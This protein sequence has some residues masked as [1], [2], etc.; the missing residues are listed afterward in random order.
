LITL[1]RNIAR[2]I[3]TIFRRALGLSVNQCSNQLV[4]LNADSDGSVIRSA[5]SRSAI[6]YRDSTSLPKCSLQA[7]LEMFKAFGSSKHDLVTLTAIADEKIQANWQDGAVPRTGTWSSRTERS[8]HDFPSAPT[9]YVENPPNFLHAIREAISTTD[10]NPTRFALNCLRLRGSDGSVA[11]TDGRQVFKQS[12][13]EFSFEDE[14]LFYPAQVYDAK[15]LPTN[16]PVSIGR[17]ETHI[18]F[19][20]GPWTFFQP[21]EKDR[22]FPRIEDVIPPINDSDSTLDWQS[23]DA[24]F[25]VD[26]LRRLPGTE[27]T[28]QPVTIDLNGKVAIRARATADTQPT[29]LVL[30]NSQRSGEEIRLAT[31]RRYLSRAAQL[32]FERVYFPDNTTPAVCNDDHRTYVWALLSKEG[33]VAPSEGT[34][35]IESPLVTTSTKQARRQN[36]QSLR[37]CRA[38]DSTMKKARTSNS[39]EQKFNPEALP[40]IEE[41]EVLPSSVIEQAIAL[42]SS[43]RDVLNQ[44]NALIESLRKQDKQRRLMKS[45][46]A[47]LRQL[48]VAG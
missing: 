48:Q 10:A 21:M 15:D 26:S 12:G 44:T 45:T 9:N 46:L 4:L 37:I 27:D 22:R 25:L 38:K 41:K 20:L 28:N 8:I 31:D 34:I 35:I 16:A 43:L 6:E 19:Q 40:A 5:T 23:A 32:G 1:S 33:I 14:V 39:S 18:V 36:D 7:P 24:A 17:T 42:R 29:E 2:Q 11:A 3:A 30:Q 13:F 47:S